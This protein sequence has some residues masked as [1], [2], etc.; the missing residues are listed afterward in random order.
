MQSLSPRRRLPRC[1]GSIPTPY[2]FHGHRLLSFPSPSPSSI[3][4]PPI[5]LDGGR[6]AALPRCAMHYRRKKRRIGS[7]AGSRWVLAAGLLAAFVTLCVRKTPNFTL[8]A[9]SLFLAVGAFGNPKNDDAKYRKIN[10]SS[11]AAFRRGV[12]IRRVAVEETCSLKRAVGFI[13]Q[14]RYLILDVYDQRENYLGE[15]RQDETR[16]NLFPSGHIRAD[17]GFFVK[18]VKKRIRIF[19]TPLQKRAL[20]AIL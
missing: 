15:I 8:L 13:E 20:Y 4:Y 10:F 7:A 17:R 3:S 6:S 5:P 11:K 1:G 16:G 2:A 14:G 18:N 12:E 19:K 9:F